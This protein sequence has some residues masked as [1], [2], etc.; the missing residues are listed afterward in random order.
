MDDVISRKFRIILA[1]SLIAGLSV[2]GTDGVDALTDSPLSAQSQLDVCR[3]PD[4]RDPSLINAPRSLGFPLNQTRSQAI[5]SVNLVLVAAEFADHRGKPSELN[6]I[7]GE[8]KKFN[9]W[10]AFQ[11]NGRLRAN[12]Q[13]PKKWIQ[14]PKRAA[15]YRIVGF[16]P[17]T[18]ESL[19]N[20]VISASDPDVQFQSIDEMF[21][22]L[23]D[24]LTKSEPNRDPFAGVLSQFGGRD[25]ST[26]EGVIK[27]IKGSGT[28]SQ[29]KQYGLAPTLW[30]LWAHDLMHAIGIEGHNPVESFTLESE[31]Y[32][33]FVLSAWNQFLVGWMRDD[34]VAC[35]EPKTLSSSKPTEFELVPLQLASSGYRTA[36]VPIGETR[37]IVVESHRKVG[38]GKN[39]GASGVLVYLMDTKNVPPY[40]QR[41]QTAQIGSRFLD[42]DRV[43]QGRRKP[44]G[45]GQ[46]RS[47]MLPGE[48]ASFDDVVVEFV[49]TG[50]TDRIRLRVKGG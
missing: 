5:G 35:I 13:F 8:V 50:K 44:I 15:D 25:V 10:L 24:S 6:K 47:I 40:E 36:I 39:L 32:L 43:A 1:A 11:S 21:V 37:A 9:A 19:V 45:R 20:D 23:P 41:S 34:Q 2:V 7:E 42:P 26:P 29:A 27:Q 38:Y 16:D 14:L 22:Y 4:R 46:V 12:W 33:N 49:K 48:T 3:L 31:D 17:K 18:H 28:V 30:A